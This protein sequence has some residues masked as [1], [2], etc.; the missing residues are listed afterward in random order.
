MRKE[1]RS[2]VREELALD[3]EVKL[4][5]TVGRL[6]AEKDPMLLLE[7]FRKI[8]ATDDVALVYVGDGR[9]R[10]QLELEIQ[11]S[12]FEN[13][14]RITGVLKPMRVARLLIAAD[15]FVLSSSYEGRPI[16]VLEALATGPPVAS[17]AVGEVEDIVK[18]EKNGFICNEHNASALADSINKCLE[19]SANSLG[20]PEITGSTNE[21]KPARVLQ[22]VYQNYRQLAAIQQ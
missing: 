22:P 6:D 8:N 13:R 2:K 9:L 4:L 7:S 3:S 19:L 18:N 12:N 1:M 15:A 5:V 20:S 16:A 14:V 11:H 21:Y 10:S 17:T